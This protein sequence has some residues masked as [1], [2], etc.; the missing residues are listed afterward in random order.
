MV[1]AA[2]SGFREV[3]SFASILSWEASII[4]IPK[5]EGRWSLPLLTENTWT[6]LQFHCFVKFQLPVPLAEAVGSFYSRSALAI[7]K[8]AGYARNVPSVAIPF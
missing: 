6:A 8:L 7:Y 5:T 4:S 2:S 1:V 3:G